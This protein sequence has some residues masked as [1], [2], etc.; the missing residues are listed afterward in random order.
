[1][2]IL[3]LDR[4]YDIHQW[5][6]VEE[7]MILEA[8]ELVLAHLGE[9]VFIYRG[10]TNKMGVD[11]RLATSSII[12]VDGIAPFRAHREPAL[13]N[14]SLFQRDRFICAYCGN[15][16]KPCDLTRDHVMPQSK[17]DWKSQ[18]RGPDHWMNVVTACKSCNSLK[19]DVVPGQKLPKANG[20][21]ILGPQGDGYMRPLYVPYV[22]CRA[23]HMIL[24]NRHIKYDQME[25]LLGRISNKQS[26][27][28]DYAK[29]LFVAR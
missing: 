20:R 25:F 27:I 26:R 6:T 4:H 19:D 13:T 29:D 28:F 7:A 24:R 11:S 14:N 5:V 16:F 15:R 10:G 17:W 2:S 23:E 18:P 1:M 9:D 21:Q 22:P 8:K 12:V 3:T